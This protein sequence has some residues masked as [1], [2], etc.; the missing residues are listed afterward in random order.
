MA[1]ARLCSVACTAP[2]SSASAVHIRRTLRT[3]PP[4]PTLS[5]LARL[6][7]SPSCLPSSAWNAS[8]TSLLSSLGRGTFTSGRSVRTSSAVPDAMAGTRRYAASSR[9]AN[10]GPSSLA[11][12]ASSPSAPAAA[13][14]GS[15]SGDTKPSPSA[16]ASEKSG[17]MLPWLMGGSNSGPS[18][19][20][21]SFDSLPSL[22]AS[23][24]L[25][26][27]WTSPI[28][29]SAASKLAPPGLHSSGASR[30][31][32]S[33]S[34]LEKTAPASRALTGGFSEDMPS[35]NSSGE[36]MPSSSRSMSSHAAC[37]EPAHCSSCTLNHLPVDTATPLA[38]A[39]P[40]VTP[41]VVE[42]VEVAV[43]FFFLSS[44]VFIVLSFSCFGRGFDAGFEPLEN[45]PASRAP[46]SS[47]EETP[48]SPSSSSPASASRACCSESGGPKEPAWARSS[49]LLSEPS[50]SSSIS[51][52]AFL[53]EPKPARR[54]WKSA[55]E[56][57]GA[58]DVVL[59]VQV[60]L[61]SRPS[62]K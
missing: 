35:E 20:N 18:A 6:T 14:P 26:T 37:R 31:S 57:G 1:V 43:A 38:A 3:V 62:W 5:A 28:G 11:S 55:N 41:A 50:S 10:R 40:V 19:T 7:S 32:P 56:R 12:S 47:S 4:S 46:K 15:S 54:D 8:P 60:A 59:V 2:P 53:G 29:A 9:S 27:F 61:F 45:L 23:M 17:S 13:G 34:S 30:P 44:A 48:P 33:R 21:S 42:V 24:L 49:C 52:N 25:Y 16:S 39:G 58:V 22:S 51:K 36:I